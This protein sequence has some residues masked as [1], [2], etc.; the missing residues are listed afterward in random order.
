VRA[1]E[2]LGEIELTELLRILI[3]SGLVAFAYLSYETWRHARE[4]RRR[5]AQQSAIEERRTSER[6]ASRLSE[7][8]V[9]LVPIA[10]GSRPA[11]TGTVVT[12]VEPWAGPLDRALPA[13]P[14]ALAGGAAAGRPLGSGPDQR[15][16]Q[17]DGSRHHRRPL[18]WLAPALVCLALVAAA[19]SGAQLAT[20]LHAPATRGAV[21]AVAAPPASERV[22]GSGTAILIPPAGAAVANPSRSTAEPALTPRPGSAAEA[23]PAGQREAVVAA[24]AM[25]QPASKGPGAGA[26]RSA[27]GVATRVGPCGA[28]GCRAYVVRPHDTLL[29]IAWRARVAISAILVANPGLANP[30]LIVAG[31]VLWLPGR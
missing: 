27:A 3:A 21:L 22:A 20:R 10:A 30:N 12:R 9:G 29:R 26:T 4:A 13:D 24:N 2:R 8:G 19:A 6:I 16:A 7:L 31:Q 25:P 14:G 1:R 15:P 5:R 23:A 18:F 11:E 17:P 28:V